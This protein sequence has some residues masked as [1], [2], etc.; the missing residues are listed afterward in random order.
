MNS[1][2]NKTLIYA[3]IVSF[4]PDL[5]RLSENINAIYPQVDKLIIVDNKS[6]NVSDIEYVIRKFKNILLIKN[7]DNLGMS[8]ALNQIMEVGL[9]NQVSWVLTLDQDSVVSESLISQYKKYIDLP[10]VGMLTCLMKDRNAKGFT[11]KE[12][13]VEYEEVQGCITSGCLT[14]VLA[15][16]EC[17][18]FDEKMFIDYVDYDMC[19]SLRERGYRIIR[20]NQVGILHE[21]GHSKDVKFLGKNH[22][23]YNHSPKRKYFIV[24]NRLYYN[25]KHA[26][27]IN[28]KMAYKGVLRFVILTL[29][30]EPNKFLNFRAMIRGALDS[31]K[32]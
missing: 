8:R 10:K 22:I 31:R 26:K 17:E 21:L 2:N 3:G 20:V 6:D 30:F 14:N 11:S 9:S 7:N 12:K 32:M 24:R 16:D 25:K 5:S 28:K 18:H 29:I 19:M 27:F 1:V 4:N 15:W 13:E 23:V